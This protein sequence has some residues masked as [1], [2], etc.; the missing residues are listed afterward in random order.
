M[1]DAVEERIVE[2]L[3]NPTLSP[4]GNPIP[5]LDGVQTPPSGTFAD[6]VVS[7]LAA[8]ADAD[9]PVRGTVRRLGEPVQYEP[10]LLQQ[11]SDAGVIPG[12]SGEFTRDGAE[13]I[14]RMDGAVSG[15]E[16]AASVASHIYVDDTSA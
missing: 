6:G 4:Y 14:V 7:L 16:L 8:T 3:G 10:G 9:A 15:V 13:V 5:T 1:S 2:L 11:L 12:G